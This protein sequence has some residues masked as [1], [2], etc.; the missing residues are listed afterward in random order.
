MEKLWVKN[1]Y[2]LNISLRLTR[3][4]DANKLVFLEH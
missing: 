1:R 4:T 3:G 2:G